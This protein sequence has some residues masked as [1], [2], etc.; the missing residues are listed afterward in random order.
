M[1]QMFDFKR[2]QNNSCAGKYIQNRNYTRKQRLEESF[3]DNSS[4]DEDE[5]GNPKNTPKVK[6]PETDEENED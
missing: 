1:T 4:L 3:S 6:K 2:L 5:F